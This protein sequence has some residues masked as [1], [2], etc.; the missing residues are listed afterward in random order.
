MRIVRTI[1]ELRALLKA[2]REGGSRI[3]FVPTM[4]YLHEGHASLIRQSTARCD[5]TVVSIFVNPTQF[6]PAEDLAKYPRDLERDQVLCQKHGAT[7]LFLPEPSEIYP[8]GFSTFVEPGE[9]GQVLCGAFRPGHFRGV[10]TVV[11]KLFNIVQP[12]LAFFGQKDLQQTVVIRR[13]VRDLNLPVDIVVAP[14]VREADGLALSSRNAYLSPEDRQRATALSRGLLAA[15]AAFRAGE[16]S[17][18]ALLALAQKELGEVDE[19]QYL[20]LVDA[21]TLER[22]ADPIARTVALCVA[23]K[24][25]TTRL[26]DNVLLTPDP[27]AVQFLSHLDAD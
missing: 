26:I 2:L 19:L 18:A 17:V 7:V 11:T 12:D 1:P 4:G 14:T 9:L 6:G 3:G 21:H 5:H 8:T 22:T 24:V 23:A 13:V 15:D 20:E 10:A 25:G 27:E 16:Q